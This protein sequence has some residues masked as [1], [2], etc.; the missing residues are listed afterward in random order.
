MRK[1][2]LVVYREKKEGKDWQV[3]MDNIQN[4]STAKR[5]AR[6]IEG[7]IVEVW[8]DITIT[9]RLERIS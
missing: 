8:V 9:Q 1:R 5:V 2:Y 6:S 3:Y 4:L 7:Y